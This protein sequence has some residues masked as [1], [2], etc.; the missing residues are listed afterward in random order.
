L[1]GTGHEENSDSRS[2]SI[3]NHG[4]FQRRIWSI[5]QSTH[6][7]LLIIFLVLLKGILDTHQYGYVTITVGR[8]S[9]MRIIKVIL[10][11]LLMQTLHPIRMQLEVPN[12]DIPWNL[13]WK[14]FK[15]TIYG[16]SLIFL[17]V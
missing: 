9:L 14:P 13:K 1:G 7:Q 10:L 8:A 3:D 2:V 5:K 17:V 16:T 15:K 11:Y 6:I 12:K 4:G